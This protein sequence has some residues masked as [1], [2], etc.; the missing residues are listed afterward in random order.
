M[1]VQYCRLWGSKPTCSGDINTCCILDSY[2]HMITSKYDERKYIMNNVKNYFPFIPLEYHTVD[3]YE[4]RHIMTCRDP[5]VYRVTI[6]YLSYL[7]LGVAEWELN[8]CLYFFAECSA[9][10]N[11]Q[12]EMKQ[13]H[14][15][16][17]QYCF[18]HRFGIMLPTD[19]RKQNFKA[20]LFLDY[21][22]LSLAFYVTNKE[23]TVMQVNTI[24]TVMPC[25][26]MSSCLR[27]RKMHDL[28]HSSSVWKPGIL[29][30]WFSVV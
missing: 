3:L 25:V 18:V 13:Q 19:R 7:W 8:A 22:R 9:K 10:K 4:T 20:F 17:F 12:E 16:I 14:E 26:E 29:K 30:V 28:T 27:A 6:Y 23:P 11:N 2:F 1:E 21:A 5:V 24:A 15:E